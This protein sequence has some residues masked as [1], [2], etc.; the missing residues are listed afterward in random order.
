VSSNSSASQLLAQLVHQQPQ[1]LMRL[2]A[3][4]LSS[5]YGL[6]AD[7]LAQLLRGCSGLRSLTLP[8]L[9]ST[10]QSNRLEFVE[11]IT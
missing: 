11:A 7:V 6:E 10:V 5:C 3:L 8:Q 9:A 2:Q 4:D 1:L